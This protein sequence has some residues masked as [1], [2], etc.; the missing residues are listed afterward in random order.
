MY[1][2]VTKVDFYWFQILVIRG[3]YSKKVGKD[4]AVKILQI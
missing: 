2:R 3:I 4:F 1:V